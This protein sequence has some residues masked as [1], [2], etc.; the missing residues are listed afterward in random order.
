[1]F[2]FASGDYINNVQLNA[3]DDL[4]RTFSSHYAIYTVAP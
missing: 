2:S 1:L 3:G 4:N